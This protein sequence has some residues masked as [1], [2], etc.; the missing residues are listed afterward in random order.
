MF[1]D[2]ILTSISEIIK[3]KE[4]YLVGGYLRNYFLNN[5]IS[6]DRDLVVLGNSKALAL[7][8]AQKLNGTFIELD[9]ENKIYRVV[10]EDKTNYFDISRALNDDISK[11]INRRDFTINS[12][13]YDLNKKEILDP[14]NGV[15][16][17]KNKVLKTA[18]FDN[19]I[20]DSLRFLRL[21]RFMS[22]T[23]FSVEDDLSK[24]VKDN[25]YLIKNVAKERINYEI[26]K[27]F[28]GEFVC[29][30]L[31][32]MFD[33]GVLEQVFPFVKEVKKIPNN[34]H[35]HL[36]LIHHLIET[37]KNIRT[38]NPILKI[39]AFYHDIGKPKTWS[40]EPSG[41]HRFIGHDLVG[42]QIALSE[43]EDLKFSNKQISY[44]TKMIKYHIYPATLIN[45]ADNKKAF[46]RFVR[47]LGADS[48]DVIELSRADRLSAL[49]PAVT[50]EMVKKSL[51]HL[52][53]LK[54]YYESVKDIVA[55]PK[56]FLDGREVMEILNLKPS[57]KVG[58]IL[59]ELKELQLSGEIKTKEEA[60]EFL[61]KNY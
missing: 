5:E 22:L 50:S 17:I 42:A 57:K 6:F 24:F 15:N 10:L 28:E 7:E 40:I 47:K 20:D 3:D 23:G 21:Y 1:S 35:H 13:F 60:L 33:D 32:K 2:D 8:I 30:T 43:L 39:A 9:S 58:Q 12:I 29:E 36:D 48:L 37:V 46:A 49:G 54:K 11:D 14:L 34:T 53:E 4:V 26:I 27:I 38:N 56:A 59:E 45:C 19:F 18:N 55:S 61:K 16:D 52:E 25:F 41:R 44:I 51:S 31:L